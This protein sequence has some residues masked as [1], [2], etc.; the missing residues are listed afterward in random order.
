MLVGFGVIVFGALIAFAVF[1][2]VA[3]SPND[4]LAQ[5]L[6][7][8][9][10]KMYGAWFCPHCAAQKEAFGTAFH[11]VTYVECAAADKSELQV[12]KD[13]GIKGYP[14]WIY[15]DGTKLDGEQPLT[16]LAEKAGCEAP[17]TSGETSSPS[18]STPSNP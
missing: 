13:A 3:P 11:Y 14:T 5:C 17:S 10:V 9:G 2:S 15:P 18:A 6:T 8:K 12:C 16:K 4:A 7:D 1:H